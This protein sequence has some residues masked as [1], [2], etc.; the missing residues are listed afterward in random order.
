MKDELDLPNIQILQESKGNDG[1]FSQWYFWKKYA[2][3]LLLFWSKCFTLT[4]SI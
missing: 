2:F 4:P 3:C 1:R